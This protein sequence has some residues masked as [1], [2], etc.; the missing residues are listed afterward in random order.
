MSVD[1]R[2]RITLNLGAEPYTDEARRVAK[3][4]H[5]ELVAAVTERRADLA[6]AIAARHFTISERLIRELVD[7]AEHEGAARG[8]RR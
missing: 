7:R 1:L 3:G 8:E 4:Q 6:A 2:A 5:A